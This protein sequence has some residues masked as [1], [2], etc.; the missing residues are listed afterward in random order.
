MK[1]R[2]LVLMLLS[3]SML[4]TSARHPLGDCF[5][6]RRDRL[7]VAV[8]NDDVATVQ[9]LLEGLC[10]EDLERLLNTYDDCPPPLHDARSGAMVEALVAAGARPGKF[11]PNCWWGL[12]PL[13][14]AAEADPQED[15]D[16]LGVLKALVRAGARVNAGASDVSRGRYFETPPLYG[17]AK[18][19]RADAVQFLLQHGADPHYKDADGCS[20]LYRTLEHRFSVGEKPHE[21]ARIAKMLF[22]C[23]AADAQ[24]VHKSCSLLTLAA[25]QGLI[26]VATLLLCAGADVNYQHDANSS[27]ALWAAV[28][29]G[30]V[31]MVA[32]LLT[33]GACKDIVCCGDTSLQLAQSRLKLSKQNVQVQHYHGHGDRKFVEIINRDIAR[34]QTIIQL[35]QEK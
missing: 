4:F 27:T 17:A 12:T 6:A 32:F 20:L 7:D 2:L 25:G 8:E 30:R 19:A 13:H 18:F 16:T 31:D 9:G 24:E 35:L 29:S 33:H 34:Y 15:G 5:N 10:P 3:Y 22:D 21:K 23:G 28:G 26:K 11:Y 1:Y 14:V